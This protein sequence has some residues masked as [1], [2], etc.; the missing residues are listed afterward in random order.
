MTPTNALAEPINIYNEPDAHDR[1]PPADE[2]MPDSF[3]RQ[4]ILPVSAEPKSNLTFFQ[5][6]SSGH[7]Y[8]ELEPNAEVMETTGHHYHLLDVSMPMLE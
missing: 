5:V 1:S 4:Y 3:G 8:H 7:Q 2:M 6:P